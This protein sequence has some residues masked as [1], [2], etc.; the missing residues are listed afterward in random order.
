MGEILFKCT[1]PSR[2]YIKKNT[3]RIVGYGK[4][5][6]AIYTPRFLAWQKYALLCMRQAWMGKPP[7]DFAV[8]AT[9][10]FYFKNKQAE[11]DL[12]NTIEG[13]Q[14]CLKTAGVIVD[15]V[16]IQVLHARKFFGGEPRTE[17][18]IRGI[19]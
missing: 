18:E 13:P 16:L 1:I 6:R 5:K 12:S 4:S 10:I 11:T 14:D 3:A 8:D 17:I 15:D 2:C 19:E 7:I 9:F